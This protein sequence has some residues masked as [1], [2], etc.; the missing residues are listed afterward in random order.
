MTVTIPSM[1]LCLEMAI[2]SVVF[3]FVYTWR[4]YVLGRK[5]GRYEGGP[6]GIKALATAF[7]PISLVSD[8]ANVI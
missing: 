8:I 5:G 3:N 1:L 2:F 7:N 6:L 4:P